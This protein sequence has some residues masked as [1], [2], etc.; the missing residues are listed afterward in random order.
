MK[1]KITHLG[2]T[3]AASMLAVTMSVSV[4]PQVQLIKAA[5]D[6]TINYTFEG[7]DKAKAG[8]AQGTITVSASSSA[9]YHLFW[10]DDTKA[11]DGYYEINSKLK[12]E[13]TSR[14]G[15]KSFEGKGFIVNSG[16]AAT[17]TF[18][19]HTA[20]PANATK[21][22]AVTDTN[23]TSV[24]D[25]VA[26]FD[27]PKE[28]QLKTGSGNLLYRFNSYSDIHLSTGNW[29]SKSKD[30]W[31]G[32]L[33]Y[34]SDKNVDFINITGDIA[35]DGKQSE[36]DIYKNKISASKYNGKI[37]ECTGNHDRKG[38]DCF[39]KN[40]L[41]E[42]DCA[43]YTNG[44]AYY[45]TIEKKTGDVFIYLALETEKATEKNV[46]S[47]EQM[48]WLQGLV[49]K[50]YT[51]GVNIFISEH[52]PYQNWSIGEFKY[53]GKLYSAHLK[54]GDTVNTF[55]NI[56]KKYKNLIWMNGHTHQ[57]FSISTNYSNENGSAC[58]MIHNPGCGG[59]TYGYNK[60]ADDKISNASGQNY[61]SP[62]AAV[63]GK[64]DGAG[65][66]SQGYYVET[67]ENEI[68]YHGTDLEKEMIYPEY[69]YI[70]EGY[71]SKGSTPVDTSE[72]KK[73]TSPS[74]T[75]GPVSGK[76]AIYFDNSSYNWSDV[77]CY[78]Y[79][80]KENNGEWPG[81]KMEKDPTTGYYYYEV[82]S[83]LS[84]GQVM[85]AE[86]KSS[87]N[88]YPA[89]KKPGL[90]VSGTMVFKAGN[91]L[92]PYTPP[93]IATATP[94][95]TETPKATETPKVTETPKA[96]E[97]PK[98]TED[99][100]IETQK[101]PSPSPKP[102]E[103]V[104]QGNQPNGFATA[105]P[106]PK[107]AEVEVG[108]KYYDENS[109]AVYKVVTKT[110][111]GGTVEYIKNGNANATKITIPTRIALDGKAYSVVSIGKNAFKGNKVV[112]KIIVGKSITKIGANAFRGCSKVTALKITS[113]KVKTIGAAAF[114]GM[115]KKLTI[116][117]PKSKKAD[118][119]KKIKKAK[120]NKKAKFK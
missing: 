102:T 12:D 99:V 47:K 83:N 43:H 109:N 92:E 91:K 13:L 90:E 116:Y 42:D 9:T 52:A 87:K 1:R 89:D 80:G 46:F 32:A 33:K 107:K 63:K 62:E 100:V 38:D 21:I 14:L 119:K 114:Y 5:S 68:I 64:E 86:S 29:W 17:F 55:I 74:E 3:V 37:W 22:I 113:T 106:T 27:I 65:F 111:L 103:N 84:T 25:A 53:G 105:T 112:K 11:L 36:W 110:D 30:R 98:P 115:S 81:V 15:G 66:H 72:P 58:N 108:K 26:V 48:E 50:Y 96:T 94:K 79:S 69:C 60:S 97:T 24:S 16:K 85:F 10:A 40:A 49:D 70:M 54:D 93:V 57:D 4:I 45:Y 120:V 51:T 78:L 82:P 2:R 59:T 28:K 56:L 19:E 88:R 73:T 6:V 77:Y 117:L 20:I 41:T 104:N 35:T 18:D 31:S 7:N 34:A 101:T 61:H 118:Y 39:K 8:Y 44:K 67:Y 71:R 76:Q 23:K 75:S 95:P